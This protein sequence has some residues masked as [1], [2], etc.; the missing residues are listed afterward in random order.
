[1]LV[2]V[3]LGREDLDELSAVLRPQFEQRLFIAKSLPIFL[4]FANPSVSKGVGLQVVADLLG[5]TAASTVAFGDGENDREL[6]EWAAYAIAVENG[7]DSVKALADFICPA[8]DE[9]G[10]AQVVEAFLAR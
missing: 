10:V 5:F 3:F 7:D 9:E 8:A 1:M 2:R 4:E 6:L